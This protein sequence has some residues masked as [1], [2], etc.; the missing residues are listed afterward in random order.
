MTGPT[1]ELYLT[2]D[3]ANILASLDLAGRNFGGEYGR[4]WS[5]AQ[6]LRRANNRTSKISRT[7]RRIT[8]Q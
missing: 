8:H 6:P 2:G 1:L 5:A 7:I 4:G 3:L